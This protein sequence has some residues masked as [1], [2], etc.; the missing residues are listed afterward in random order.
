MTHLY[1]EQNTGLTEEVNYSVIS[2]LYELAI[3]GDLD[4]TS[5][6]KGRLHT[7]TARD[8]H[9]AYLTTTFPDLHITA[10][11]AYV[12]FA[13]SEV[14]K[15]LAANWGDGY[16]VSLA[17]MGVHNSLWFT[18]D[19]FPFK[20]NTN[21]TTFNELGNFSNITEIGRQQFDGASN[22]SS[23]NLTNIEKIGTYAFRGTNLTTVNLPS[24]EQLGSSNTDEGGV[25]RGCS[26]LTTV[27]LGANLSI[28][29]YRC[30]ADCDNLT[31]V[32][33][34]S[35]FT[36]VPYNTFGECPNLTTIDVDFSKITSVGSWAFSNCSSI[37]FGT[38]S[39]PNLDSIGS[40]SFEGCV[41]ITSIQNLGSIA[42][43]NNSAFK[44]CSNLTTV[45][46]PQSVT[47]IGG[48]CFRNCTKLQSITLPSGIVAIESEAFNNCTALSG[49]LNLPN[50]TSIGV[51]AF[52]TTKITRILNLGNISVLPQAFAGCTN[53]TEVIF[54][55]S[56]RSIS[57]SCFNRS[58]LQ[59]FIIPEGVTTIT[60]GQTDLVNC[61]Y[62]EIPSTVTDMGI[63]FHRSMEH[64]AQ[65]QCVLVIK[66]TNPPPVTYYG[67]ETD[68]YN[69]NAYSYI[70]VPDDSLNA[71][72]S[73]QGGWQDPKVQNKL[74]AISYLETDNPTA[75]TEYQS[76]IN[77]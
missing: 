54:P 37:S 63:F 5:D 10:D 33:G 1:I 57:A 26:N 68:A 62:I 29:K 45:V 13:D 41:G 75:W 66:A 52:N 11:V 35:D 64:T 7:P 48:N 39:I 58:L 59:K 21:V 40:N 6:L 74:R 53:L 24:I 72:L 15:V 49:E 34:L 42:T 19:Y 47:V 30:F 27:S 20:D 14:D 9:V 32:T 12:T 77:S 55:Q 28:L 44:N 65:N 18:S 70:Y 71:Y 3:S 46:L 36:T 43:L 67:R 22:L 60:G 56:M 61:I 31:Q 23:I 76:R 2:K 73:A 8:T 4:E 38:L 25:F 69:T 16:G 51:G 50:L 17:Q